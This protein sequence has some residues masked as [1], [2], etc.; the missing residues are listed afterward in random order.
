MEQKSNVSELDKIVKQKEIG[1]RESTRIQEPSIH[2]LRNPL[3]QYTGK[4]PKENWSNPEEACVNCLS[5]CE[6]ICALILMI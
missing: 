3:K 6:F 2:T 1:P 5:L 4:Y